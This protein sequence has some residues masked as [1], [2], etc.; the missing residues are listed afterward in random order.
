VPKRQVIHVILDPVR[1]HASAEVAVSLDYRPDR[2]RFHWRPTHASWLSFVEAWFA[3]LSKKCLKR[4]ELADFAAAA[5][6]IT[7]FVAPYHA[8]HAHPFTWTK[9]GRFYRRLKD[10]LA[11]APAPPMA[12]DPAPQEEAMAA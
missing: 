7:A 2:F 4:A 9:G 12:I 11:Q 6:T 3:I 1:L 8:H 10:K 5:T